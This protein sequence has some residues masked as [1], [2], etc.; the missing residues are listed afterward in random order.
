MLLSILFN[1]YF[2]NCFITT[3]Q[4]TRNII[5]KLFGNFHRTRVFYVVASLV[6]LKSVLCF[7]VTYF[8]V[9]EVRPHRQVYIEIGFTC[10]F[11]EICKTV[12]YWLFGLFQIVFLANFSTQAAKVPSIKFRILWIFENRNALSKRLR[13]KPL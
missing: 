2:A 7:D 5:L 3:C 8:T 4:L 9:E 13:P 10:K 1:Y 11:F 12:K 6:S